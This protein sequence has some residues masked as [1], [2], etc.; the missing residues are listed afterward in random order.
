MRNRTR[1]V[2]HRFLAVGLACALAHNAIM[3]AGD[4]LGLHYVV[5][6]VISFVLVVSFG[7]W[8]HSGWTFSQAQRNSAS[9]VRYALMAAMNLPLSI[10][11]MFVLVDIAGFV[12]PFASPLVTVLLAVFNFAGSRW[13]LRRAELKRA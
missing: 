10:F 9:F 4:R 2:V 12:V 6:S 1:G 7:Y 5:S 11:G 3:I 8:L 13:A